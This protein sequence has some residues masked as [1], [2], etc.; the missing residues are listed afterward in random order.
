MDEVMSVFDRIDSC[1][2]RLW[3]I[4]PLGPL[5]N[6]STWR[7]YFALCVLA[8]TVAWA[9]FGFDSTWSQLLPYQEAL[10][11]GTLSLSTLPLLR[12]QSKAYYGMGNHFSAPVIYGLAFIALSNYF[13]RVG[14][15]GSKNFAMSTGMS[16][17][18]IGI[19][20]LM[21]NS[22]YAIFQGQTWAITF[23]W[24]QV[25]NLSCFVAFV[26]LGSLCALYLFTEGFKIVLSRR[27]T[28][29]LALTAVM[30]CLW[31]LYPFPVE[32]LTVETTA[33]TW[34]SSSRFPQTYYAVDVA[35]GDSIAIGEP[36]WVENNLVHFVN[37]LTKVV[38]TGAIL[39]LF[40]MR[41]ME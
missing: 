19:F 29:L 12:E 14:I 22:S 7:K 37:T 21:W 36:H 2:S 28:A 25:T 34:T 20:E 17:A 15:R 39:E 9:Y 13:E 31:I 10:S 30:W 27:A 4:D 16:L 8:C 26:V 11:S 1:E 35:P 24:K 32:R 23:K 5:K 3:L 18:N 40:K 33:G 38:Q 6:V 41:R